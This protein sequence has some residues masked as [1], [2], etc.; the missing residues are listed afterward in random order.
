MDGALAFD[1]CAGWIA[2]ALEHSIGG[3]TLEDVRQAVEAGELQLWPG[4][5]A[6]VVTKL[7]EYPSFTAIES[8]AAGGDGDEIVNVLVPRAEAWGRSNG[9][10]RA[11]LVGR[12]GWQKRMKSSGYEPLYT[13]LAKGL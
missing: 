1:R 6:A 7:A 4:E 11:H 8:I 10:T 13:V 9:A 12:L 3:W 2:A 5:R